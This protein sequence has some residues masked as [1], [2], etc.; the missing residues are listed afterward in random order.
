VHGGDVTTGRTPHGG[1]EVRARL[2]I[3]TVKT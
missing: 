1:F 2:P 3:E